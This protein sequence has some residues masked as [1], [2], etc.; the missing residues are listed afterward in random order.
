MDVSI[1]DAEFAARLK[2]EAMTGDS[3]ED[4]QK[5]DDLIIEM[6]LRLGCTETKK[7]F[8][9]VDKWYQ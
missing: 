1:L 9:A 2:Q 8:E 6:L 7:A 4:H 3:E 5:A